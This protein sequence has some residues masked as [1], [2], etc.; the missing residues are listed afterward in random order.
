LWYATSLCYADRAEEA[1]PIFKKALRLNPF[2]PTGFYLSYGMALRMT[3]WFEEAASEYK[4][5]LQLE[6][7]NVLAHASL[8]ATYTV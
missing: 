4:K 2:A 5:A 1:I 8:A 6:P 3:G 7:D